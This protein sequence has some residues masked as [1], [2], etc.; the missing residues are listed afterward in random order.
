MSRVTEAQRA[1]YQQVGTAHIPGVV[2]AAAVAEL[3]ALLDDVIESLRNGN[4][5]P[6]PV[7]DPVF[8]DIEFEDHDGYVAAGQRHA[9]RA[10][11]SGVAAEGRCGGGRC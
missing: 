3:T 9:A 11:H 8:R 4:L 10:G 1:S 6:R 5:G 7:P 2:D